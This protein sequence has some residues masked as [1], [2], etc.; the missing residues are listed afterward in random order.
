MPVYRH[1]E[2][3]LKTCSAATRHGADSRTGLFL[4]GITEAH[5]G[6]APQLTVNI[7][8]DEPIVE[9]R[10]SKASRNEAP[11]ERIAAVR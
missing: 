11:I 7:S 4:H 10:S 2:R 6:M 3:L 8:A 1:T 5:L 9:T